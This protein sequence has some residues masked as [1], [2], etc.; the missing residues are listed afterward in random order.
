MAQAKAP[1]TSAQPAPA[2]APARKRSDDEIAHA[3]LLG[4]QAVADILR[5]GKPAPRNVDLALVLGNQAAQYGQRPTEAASVTGPAAPKAEPPAPPPAAMPP[6][7]T[8]AST[9]GPTPTPETAAAPSP[10]AKTEGTEGTSPPAGPGVAPTAAA[11]PSTGAPVS[12]GA[13]PKRGGGGAAPAASAGSGSPEVDAWQ[14]GVAQAANGMPQP[15]VSALEKADGIKAKGQAVRTREEKHRTELGGKAKEQQPEPPVVKDPK[16]PDDLLPDNTKHLIDLSGLKLADQVIPALI[17][18]PRGTMPVLGTGPVPVGDFR[19][20]LKPDLPA[21]AN[22]DPKDVDAETQRLAKL[23]A[24]LLAPPQALDQKGPAEPITLVDKGP[25]PAPKFPP[26]L[27]AS[28]GD[29]VAQLLADPEG[30]AKKIL[31]EVRKPLYKGKLKDNFPTLGDDL[32][33]DLTQA[34]D[35]QLHSIAAHAGVTPEDLEARVK[36]RKEQLA[37]Q[38]QQA[39]DQLQSTTQATNQCVADEAQSTNASIAGT[40]AG[41]CSDA[42]QKAQQALAQAPPSQAEQ[43]RDRY[44]EWVTQQAAAEVTSYRQAG[45]TRKTQLDMAEQQQQAAYQLV[46]QKDYLAVL[47]APPPNTPDAEVQVQARQ[48]QSWAEEQGKATH[49]GFETLRKAAAQATSQHST[50]ILMAADEARVAARA[51]SDKETGETRGWFT[52]FFDRIRDWQAQAKANAAAWAEVENGRTAVAMAGDLRDV[53]AVDEAARKGITEEAMLADKSL[54]DQQRTI[55]QAYFH[56]EKA[57][58]MVGAAAAGL[59]ARLAVQHGIEIAHQIEDKLCAV[60]D[61]GQAPQLDAIAEADGGKL[62]EPIAEKIHGAL[63]HWFHFRMDTGTVFAEL[64]GVTKIQA[65]SVRL[66]FR[67]KFD[68]D[69]D[70]YLDDKLRS[71]ENVRAQAE[72]S[73]D[74]A[75]ADAAAFEAAIHWYGNDTEDMM[76][77]LRQKTPEERDAFIAAYARQYGEGKADAIRKRIDDQLSGLGKQRADA[78][79][80]LDRDKADAIGY[81]MALPVTQEPQQEGGEQQPM[82]I[83]DRDRI[84]RITKTVTDEVKA[85]GDQEGWTTAQ[86]NAEITRRLRAVSGNFQTLYGK[87][88][89]APEGGALQTAISRN[90]WQGGQRDLVNA[91]VTNDVAGVEAAHIKMEDEGLWASDKVINRTLEEPYLRAVEDVRRDE[92]PELHKRMESKMQAELDAAR[93]EAK[94]HNWPWNEYDEARKRRQDMEAAF[95]QQLSNDALGTA[96]SNMSNLQAKFAGNYGKSLN[97]VVSSDTSGATHRKAMTLLAQSGYLTNAQHVWFAKEAGDE[98]EAKKAVFGRTKGELAD[99]KEEYEREHP[100]A[101]FET[102]AKDPVGGRDLH[103]MK[104]ALQ[105]QPETAQEQLERL[106]ADLEYERKTGGESIDPDTGEVIKRPEFVWLEKQVAAMQKNVDV[107]Y[108]KNAT[109]DDKRKAG[110]KFDQFTTYAKSAI[111]DH[112]RAVDAEVEMITTIAAVVVAV[113][114]TA[115]T[116]GLAGPVVAAV[117]GSVAATATTIGLKYAIKGDAYSAKELKTDLIIGAVDAAMAGLTAGLAGKLLGKAAEGAERLGVE[118]A[119]RAGR[120]ALARAVPTVEWMARFVESNNVFKKN[121]ALILAH[122]AEALVQGTPSAFVGSLL[123]DANWEQGDPL[124]NILKGTIEQAGTSLAFALALQ[125]G[126]FIGGKAYARAVKAFGGGA[127]IEGGHAPVTRP[128]EFTEHPAD[129]AKWLAAADEAA[130]KRRGEVSQ[131]H[132]SD[133]ADYGSPAREA[134][135]KAMLADPAM[136]ERVA[137]VH[138]PAVEGRGVE[139]KWKTKLGGVSEVSIHVGPDALPSDVA[140]H[141]DTV[142]VVESYGGLSGRVRALLERLRAWQSK[143]ALPP[144]FSKAWAAGIEVNKLR[145][146]VDMRLAMLEHAEIPP[147]SI[148]H[149]ADDF[150]HLQKQ[151]AEH[152]ATMKAMD[153]DPAEGIAMKDKPAAKP[154]EPTTPEPTEAE[155]P[156]GEE[157]APPKRKAPKFAERKV[158]MAKTDPSEAVDLEDALA[159]R[160]AAGFSDADAGAI[161]RWSDAIKLLKSKGSPVTIDA[162]LGDLKPG[163]GERAYN[164]FRYRVFDAILDMVLERGEGVAPKLSS[165]EKAKL[166]RDF[167]GT[168]PDP[169]SIGSLN[170]KYRAARFAEPG[171]VQTIEGIKKSLDD[172]SG[173]VA[174][175]SRDADGAMKIKS[176]EAVG[177]PHDGNYAVDDKA[178]RSF[179][180]KQATDVSKLA[181]GPDGITMGGQKME[182]YIYWCEDKTRADILTSKLN[183]MGLSSKLHVAYIDADGVVQWPR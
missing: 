110:D 75:L 109:D 65:A 83:G 60:K 28:I 77:A 164:R 126:H 30:Q 136:R 173:T 47:N 98:D 95:E 148:P 10:T 37:A 122:G 35:Q 90:I 27:S 44:I 66:S 114:V 4:N 3:Q 78:L 166:L 140:L 163:Y 104:Q 165:A 167:L 42:D 107:L 57:H 32:A 29:V 40:Q 89:G 39:N 56:G 130:I 80:D 18:S 168:M 162:M 33:A 86:V 61:V 81:R 169:A 149:I 93:K 87:D 55:I 113:V 36:L 8:A 157:K 178:G 6:A 156:Q 64:Q 172:P 62:M 22:A 34:L 137:I 175:K 21:V 105:G 92:G 72:L 1:A 46:G 121:L 7:A 91:L 116:G 131:L 45:E 132:N 152:E 100:G 127:G 58:D 84:E 176:Q 182:G 134:E 177:G 14:A 120:G 128:T 155:P 68:K 5:T 183:K 145:T 133:T 171:D 25:Q 174:G 129:Y 41:L 15:N 11:A 23:R 123:N 138:D 71:D 59:H 99:M 115:A 31:D 79:M 125:G 53:A 52:E 9:A 48:A 103:D 51:W 20:L 141:L 38:A 74:K 73:G 16:P 13:G 76:A 17:P 88:Y 111:E 117:L 102:D 108:D 2:P 70:E 69:F 142:K 94:D 63:D 43:R 106:K 160:K 179:D 180:A 144:P 82:M 153:L 147:E 85:Q 146:I 24:D 150:A 101:N 49:T 124:S 135:L 118:A 12:A 67:A 112:R 139:V 97:D 19:A 143:N 96:Q 154:G 119:E 158:S 50:D 170:S 181:D 151:I 161:R 54:T 159:K 26:A